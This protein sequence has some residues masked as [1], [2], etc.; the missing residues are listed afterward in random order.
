[1]AARG[2][3]SPGG[4]PHPKGTVLEPL[5]PWLEAY[6]ARLGDLGIFGGARPNHVLINEYRPGEGIMV[7]W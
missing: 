5:P 2:G 3:A 6:A 4:N 1:M 7:R